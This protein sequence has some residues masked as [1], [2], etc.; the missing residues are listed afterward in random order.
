MIYLSS[1]I[2]DYKPILSAHNFSEFQSPNVCTLNTYARLHAQTHTHLLHAAVSHIYEC[3]YLESAKINIPQVV[4][5]I[6]RCEI[7]CQIE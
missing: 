6:C 4:N 1:K 5:M 7:A 3:I 2:L